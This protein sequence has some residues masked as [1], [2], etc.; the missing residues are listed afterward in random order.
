MSIKHGLASN[1][2]LASKQMSP[3]LSA[4]H[5]VQHVTRKKLQKYFFFYVGCLFPKMPQI[6][7]GL[8]QSLLVW[9][10][11]NVALR[12]DTVHPSMYETVQEREPCQR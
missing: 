4:H 1:D 3:A 12:E 8:S 10:S 5:I 6:M 9:Q 7:G 2:R 11:P